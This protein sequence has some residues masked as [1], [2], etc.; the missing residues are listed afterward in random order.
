[1][2][3]SQAK[4]T[5]EKTTAVAKAGDWGDLPKEYKL[6]NKVNEYDHD[7]VDELAEAMNEISM[8]QGRINTLQML[9]DEHKKYH[10]FIWKTAEGICMP[11][12]KIGTDHLS[13]ILLHISGN[14]RTI[15]KELRAEALSRG[16]SIPVT[17]FGRKFYDEFADELN[18]M[19]NRIDR[20]DIV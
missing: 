10:K 12:H 1:V 6:L 15:S 3:K 16:L 8:L 17:V 19:R 11:F 18:G 4:T 20:G 5:T 9:I 14:G 7:V 2:K 13:N